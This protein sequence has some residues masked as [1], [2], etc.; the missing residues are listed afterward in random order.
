[1]RYVSDACASSRHPHVV[2]LSLCIHPL[3]PF[4][5]RSKRKCLLVPASPQFNI[6]LFKTLGLVLCH[7]VV[8]PFTLFLLQETREEAHSTHDAFIA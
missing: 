5:H 1:M 2:A 4:L 3:P 8:R 6:G 7:E